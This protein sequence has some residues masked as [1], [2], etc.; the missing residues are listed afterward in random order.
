[1]AIHRQAGH[2]Y[3]ALA[4]AH[5]LCILFSTSFLSWQPCLMKVLL[6]PLLLHDV[7][8]GSLHENVALSSVSLLRVGMLVSPR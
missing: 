8:A 2:M 3:Q 7:T 5:A 6:L 4:E 1:M